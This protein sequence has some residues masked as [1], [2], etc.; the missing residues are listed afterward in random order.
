MLVLTRRISE[1]IRID[2]NIQVTV[3]GINGDQVKLGIDAPK[4]INVWRSEL[5][6]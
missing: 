2:N 3:V 5:Q 6:K 1:R 4:E